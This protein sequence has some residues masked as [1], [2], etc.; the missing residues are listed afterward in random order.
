[1]NNQLIERFAEIQGITYEEAEEKIGAPTD[2]EILKNIEE[3]T[4]KLIQE[5]A[6]VKL[7]RAQRRA[8]EKKVGK[9]KAVE[10][11]AGSGDNPASILT[12][13]SKKLGYIDLIQKVR[14][15]NEK[16]EKENESNET[17]N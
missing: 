6:N 15:L 13:T 10:I 3:F 7:N 2:E 11:C 8:L 12:E 17:A 1:M 9:K 16:N 14:A 5:R 4:T